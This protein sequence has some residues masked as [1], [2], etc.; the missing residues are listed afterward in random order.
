MC[1]AKA[2]E[3]LS[4]LSLQVAIM[5]KNTKITRLCIFHTWKNTIRYHTKNTIR[6]RI[7]YGFPDFWENFAHAQMAKTRHSFRPSVNA[8]YAASSNTSLQS[9]LHT[10][11]YGTLSSLTEADP[12]I[13]TA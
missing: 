7:P 12:E 11:V 1:K 3:N 6:G 5:R 4:F 10:P 8:R 13:C 2:D 9:A